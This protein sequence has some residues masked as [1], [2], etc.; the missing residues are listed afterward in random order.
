[1]TQ[2]HDYDIVNSQ[3]KTFVI[4]YLLILLCDEGVQLKYMSA[5]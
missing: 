3:E 4:A 1:M 5:M 2:V